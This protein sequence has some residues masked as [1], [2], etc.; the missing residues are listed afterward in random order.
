IVDLGAFM[1]PMSINSKNAVAGNTYWHRGAVYR[2]GTWHHLPP[3]TEAYAISKDGSVI[4]TTSTRRG[5]GSVPTLWPHNGD[6][7]VMQLP[8]TATYAR[9]MAINNVDHVA[10]YFFPAA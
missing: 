2:G 6:A 10:G 7:I 1:D 4:G 9:P 5:V 3:F 8:G